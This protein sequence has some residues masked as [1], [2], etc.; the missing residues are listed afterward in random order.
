MFIILT[1]YVS[2]T[3]GYNYQQQYIIIRHS[4]AGLRKGLSTVDNLFILQS[5]FEILKSTKNKLFSAFID[6]KQ[7]FDNVLRGGLF[8][9]LHA[10]NI[11]GKCLNLIKICTAI[12]NLEFLQQR[13]ARFFS[14]L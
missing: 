13:V 2:P 1:I 4:Q 12:S 5:F 11:N 3:P 10:Y 14:M 7:A 6:F 8:C 9:S